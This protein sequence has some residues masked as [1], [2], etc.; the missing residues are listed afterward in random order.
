LARLIH[1]T[2]KRKYAPAINQPI[3][4]FPPCQIARYV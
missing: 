2:K 4:N 1:Q 3:I